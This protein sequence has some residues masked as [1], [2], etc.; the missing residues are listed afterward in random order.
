MGI[1]GKLLAWSFVHAPFVAERWVSK[2]GADRGPPAF[3]R[4]EKKLSELRLGLVTTG[5]VHHHDDAPFKRQEQS[6]HGDGSFRELDLLRLISEGHE[7]THDWYDASDAREDIDLV[8]PIKGLQALVDEGL[9]GGL[10]PKGYGLMGHVE[11]VEEHMLE[12]V[13]APKIAG[14]LQAAAVDAVLLVPA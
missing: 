6:P 11:G 5:G 3:A 10:H 9:L 14:L 2:R 8:L 12:F 1:G 4:L 13:S 7:I